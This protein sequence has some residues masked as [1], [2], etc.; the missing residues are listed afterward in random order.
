LPVAIGHAHSANVSRRVLPK[1]KTKL[2][3]QIPASKRE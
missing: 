2:R 1:A 3:K